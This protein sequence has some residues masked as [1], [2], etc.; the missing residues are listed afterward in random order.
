MIF[1]F[2]TNCSKDK[3]QDSARFCDLEPNKL[4]TRQSQREKVY[5]EIKKKIRVQKRGYM[6][7]HSHTH[8]V[9][10]FHFLSTGHSLHSECHFMHTFL[11]SPLHLNIILSSSHQI[12]GINHSS[13]NAPLLTLQSF[14]SP[15]SFHLFTLSQKVLRPASVSWLTISY[16]EQYTESILEAIFTNLCLDVRNF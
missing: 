2:C 6:H 11:S 1:H 16:T 12:R 7:N 15:L 5:Y 8:T 14:L 10:R 9:V 13:G 3:R 4:Y